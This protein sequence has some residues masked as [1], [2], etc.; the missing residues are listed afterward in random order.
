MK[1]QTRKIISFLLVLVQLFV[2]F[3]VLQPQAK[4]AAQSESETPALNET[5]VGTVKFQSFNF[6]GDNDTGEDG[7]D[8]K[9][10]FYYSDDYFSPSAINDN[11]NITD[12]KQTWEM[13]DNPSLAACSMDF[14][15]ASYTSAIDDVLSQST[16]TWR[17]TNYNR[18]ISADG[19]E[20][21][22][23]ERNV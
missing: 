18:W 3:P 20:G 17:N 6:L 11:P 10:T 15:V 23:K 13:L 21:L 14:A 5:I 22:V 9:T 4:A 7:T 12:P 1:N 8:Y 19:Y 2:L 16:Q